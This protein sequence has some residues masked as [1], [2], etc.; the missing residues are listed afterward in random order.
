MDFCLMLRYNPPMINRDAF[1][2]FVEQHCTEV[3]AVN[4]E[5]KINSI[6][7]EDEGLHLWCNPQK[8]AYHCFK[9]D[10][11]GN[12]FDLVSQIGKCS[13]Q[14]AVGLL[15][16]DNYLRTLEAKLD[17]FFATKQEAK[18]PVIVPQLALPP[19]TFP[20]AKLTGAFRKAAEDYVKSRHLS[21]ANLLFCISGKYKNRIII[22]YYDR[23]GALVYWNGRDIGNGA[24]Y[25]GP[26]FKDVLVGKADVLFMESWPPASSKVYLTE[27]EF[28]AMSLSQ[29]HFY[30]CAIGGKVVSDKQVDLL[31]PYKVCICF[32]TDK[33]GAEALHNMGDK[34]IG[35]GI[36][37]VSYVRPPANIKDWN[38]MLTGLGAN[39][40][41]LYVAS[42]EKPYTPWTSNALRLNNI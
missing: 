29:C 8:N 18:P 21:I 16:D 25:R 14:E 38:K 27:G 2:E 23:T 17:K 35:N 34:L 13:Y 19:A 24:R 4:N 6:F 3:K 40:V 12:L 31:R 41:G 7:T 28:D 10:K 26:D 36:Q 5:I 42:Q 22:P 39:L 15:T 37:E 33:S 1:L 11:S 32:D 30:G 9:T 20:I